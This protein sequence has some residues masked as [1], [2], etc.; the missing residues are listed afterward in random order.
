M[1]LKYGRNSN[2]KAKAKQ[3]YRKLITFSLYAAIRKYEKYMYQSKSSLSIF[4]IWFVKYIFL[5]N[6]RNACDYDDKRSQSYDRLKKLRSYI[7]GDCTQ[8][9]ISDVWSHLY[10]LLIKKLIFII[11]LSNNFAWCKAY[12]VKHCAS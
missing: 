11:I 9:I 8:S 4:R 7:I 5:I 10:I 6:K 3:V 2:Q 1:I 12:H